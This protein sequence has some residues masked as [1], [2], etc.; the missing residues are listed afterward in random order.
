MSPDETMSIQKAMGKQDQIPWEQTR[1]ICYWTVVSM[2][3]NEL[4]LK[5]GTIKKI[6]VPSD[7]FELP[8]DK[9]GNKG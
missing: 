2:C 5:D 8:W 4:K 7:L 1:T 3:G 6:E 9:N